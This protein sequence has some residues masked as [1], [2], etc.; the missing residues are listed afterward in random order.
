MARG[1]EEQG[2]DIHK[3][4]EAV[5]HVGIS[6]GGQGCAREDFAI[7]HAFANDGSGY[8]YLKLE[9]ATPRLDSALCRSL[10]W[11]AT[12]LTDQYGL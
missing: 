1:S 6:P 2:S 12:P 3:V 8:S 7:S 11:M 5:E 10:G 9:G 4:C